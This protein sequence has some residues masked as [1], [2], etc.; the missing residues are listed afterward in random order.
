MIP[1]SNLERLLRAISATSESESEDIFC[2][3][4]QALLA[5]YIELEIAGEHAERAYPAVARHLVVCPDCREEYDALREVLTEPQE[6]SLPDI[7]V[8]M[9]RLP[10]IPGA[11]TPNLVAQWIRSVPRWVGAVRGTQ[12]AGEYTVT[13]VALGTGTAVH[14]LVDHAMLRGYFT[15]PQPHL[16]GYTARLYSITTQPEFVV[17]MEREAPLEDL[18]EFS[19]ADLPHSDYVLTFQLDAGEVPVVLLST[20]IWQA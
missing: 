15:P 3:Q 5:A 16:Y 8:D 1:E 6:M 10:P 18:G 20:D 7:I 13:M 2:D 9:T 12:P 14:L 4:T 19:F 17:A 11:P